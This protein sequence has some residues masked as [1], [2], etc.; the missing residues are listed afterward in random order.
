MPSWIAEIARAEGGKIS[1]ER[2]M[3]LALYDPD[4]GYYT[5]NIPAIGTSGDFATATTVSDQ[6]ARS[7]ANWLRA[8]ARHL[9]LPRLNV[10]ELGAGSGELARDILRTIRPWERVHYQI[11]ETSGPL[12]I[13]Q[14]RTLRGRRIRWQAAIEPA[15]ETAEGEAMVISNEFV[16]AFPHRRFEYTAGG[17]RE[18]TIAL[19]AGSWREHLDPISSM[20]GS[21]VFSIQWMAGQRV[22]TLGSYRLWLAKMVPHLLRG[23]IL[24]I[25]YGGSPS[26]IYY[27]KPRG[28]TRA[29]FRHERL[30]EM[31]I[32][33]RAGFQDLTADVNFIDLQGWGEALGLTTVHFSTQA[34]FIRKWA[35][36]GGCLGEGPHT[37]ISNPDGMGTAMKVLHQRLSQGS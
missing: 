36:T 4:R 7:I 13:V 8:E 27:R 26:E 11:V 3:E 20:P 23:S 29:F 16:D 17:W 33:L 22:E 32:Y 31:E 25:D 37:Y 18:V 2:F 5:R 34:D 6:L 21:G 24:T 9:S 28:S 10:I 12:R 14:R 19:D 15:L 1:F 35:S 30:Q